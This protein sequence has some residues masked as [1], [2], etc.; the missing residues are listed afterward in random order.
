MEE[1]RSWGRLTFVASPS[2]L[3]SDAG[4]SAREAEI[5]AA[6]GERLT[7]AEIAARHYISVRTV[8]NHLQSAY[9]KLGVTRRQDLGRLLSGTADDR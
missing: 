8:D 5:L 3:L 4:V 9:R 6:L 2:H 1:L 7:N